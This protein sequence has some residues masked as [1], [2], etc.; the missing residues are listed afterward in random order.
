[1]IKIISGKQDT[2]SSVEFGACQWILLNIIFS[3]EFTQIGGMLRAFGDLLLCALELVL[4]VY[5]LPTT[6]YIVLMI[7]AR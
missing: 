3:A 7:G 1:M 4:F 2:I 5:M 6:P